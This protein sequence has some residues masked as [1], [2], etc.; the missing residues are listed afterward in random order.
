[1]DYFG[2]GICFISLLVGI[3]ADSHLSQANGGGFHSGP[4]YYWRD[5]YGYIPEDAFPTGNP[6]YFI[7]QLVRGN[8]LVPALVKKEGKDIVAEYTWAGQPYTQSHDFQILATTDASQFEFKETN[9][10]DLN[11]LMFNHHLVVGGYDDGFPSYIG[12]AFVNQKIGKV[13]T[14]NKSPGMTYVR[15]GEAVRDYSY[16]V[17]V[18]KN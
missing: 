16:E 4:D 7:G 3:Q 9:A 15:N 14:H 10:D 5:F 17:L 8:T 6:N 11:L 1:M 18:H 12:R 13:S 2:V